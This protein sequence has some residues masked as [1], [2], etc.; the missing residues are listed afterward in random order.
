MSRFP[1]AEP[2]SVSMRWTLAAATAVASLASAAAPTAAQ[3]IPSPYDFVE[4]SQSVQLYGTYISADQGTI[5][6]GP[7]SGPAAALGYTLRISG[8]F[9]LDTRLTYFPTTR[10]V[11]DLAEPAPDTATLRADPTAGLESLGTADLT[12]LMLD[13]SLRF[14]LTGPRT[15][16]RLQPFALIGVGGVVKASSNNAVEENL[17]TDV[18]LRVRFH[19]GFT[20]HVGAGVEWHASDHLSLRFDAR[21]LLWKLHIPQGFINQ[22]RLISSEEWVQT[23]QLNL[24]L[25]LRF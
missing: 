1:G 22:G 21:D 7:A 20:G 10:P 16:H 4:S 3:T 12:L 5:G 19:D 24:G 2:I 13:A 11:Y 23:G 15:W 14:D 8:P 17:P 25:A 9:E 6:T 18:D